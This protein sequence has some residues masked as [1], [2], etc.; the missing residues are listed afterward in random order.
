MLRFL[1]TTSKCYVRTVSVKDV[2]YV[3]AKYSLGDVLGLH[4]ASS[5]RLLRVCLPLIDCFS[6]V[7]FVVL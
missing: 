1:V 2:I 6:T 3:T 5:D 4:R 7:V